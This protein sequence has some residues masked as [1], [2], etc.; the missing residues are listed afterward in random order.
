MCCLKI[1]S[2]V[3]LEVYNSNPHVVTTV[4]TT[5]KTDHKTNNI[6]ILKQ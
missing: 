2:S 3:T 5:N 4:I 1:A 6:Y